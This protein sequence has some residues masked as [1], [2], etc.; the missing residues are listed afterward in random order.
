VAFDFLLFIC[1]SLYVN[2]RFGLVLRILF[3][4]VEVERIKERSVK[5]GIDM[6]CLSVSDENRWF[7][8]PI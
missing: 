3:I 4:S 5:H 6:V 8:P 2:V 1:C 7:P